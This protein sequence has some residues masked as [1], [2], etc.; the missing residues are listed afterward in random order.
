M[1]LESFSTL[2]EV[3]THTFLLDADVYPKPQ[4]LQSAVQAH[5]STFTTMK[6]NL[7]EA[8]SEWLL[9]G[10]HTS[11]YDDAVIS[12]Q[13]LAQHLGGMRGGTTLQAQIIKSNIAKLRSQRDPDGRLSGDSADERA[14]SNEAIDSFSA[15][16]DDLGPPVQGLSVGIPCILQDP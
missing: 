7:S 12:M 1:T 2:L 10:R 16:V 15:M 3:L 6:R 11:A 9:S 13:R 4:K 5:Q 8:K 14:F